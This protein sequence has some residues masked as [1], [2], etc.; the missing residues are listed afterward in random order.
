MGRQ[1]ADVFDDFVDLRIAER[2]AES[3]HRA[4]LAVLDSVADEVVISL[5]IH[6][7]RPLA[8]SATAVGVTPA[9]GGREQLTDIELLVIRSARSRL[10]RAR[11]QVVNRKERGQCRGRERHDLPSQSHTGQP[12]LQFAPSFVSSALLEGAASSRSL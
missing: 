7:L 6:E 8:G 4:F 5:A 1:G 3:R 10:L 11:R 2:R 9:T 12:Y